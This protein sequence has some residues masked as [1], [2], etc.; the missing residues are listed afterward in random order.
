M[1]Y[2]IYYILYCILQIFTWLGW[3]GC[4]TVDHY[5]STIYFNED[6]CP[7]EVK[8]IDTWCS[9]L[10]LP[11]NFLFL[12]FGFLL[13]K[14]NSDWDLWSKI[15]SLV[16]LPSDVLYRFLDLLS[17]LPPSGSYLEI[18]HLRW[19]W[20]KLPEAKAAISS[21]AWITLVDCPTRWSLWYWYLDFY[22]DTEMTE[23]YV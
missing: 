10:W 9:F 3:A 2:S 6:Y 23:K 7:F 19:N 1:V 4:F 11:V 18:I 16:S 8:F 5:N 22:V 17:H 14:R 20:I 13:S 15:L 21:T 12:I